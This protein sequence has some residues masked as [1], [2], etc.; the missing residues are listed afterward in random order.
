MNTETKIAQYFNELNFRQPET[1]P[2]LHAQIVP[3]PLGEMLA[4]CSATGLCL[5]EFVGQ[6]RL[7]SEIRQIAQAKRAAIFFQPHD[8]LK[9]VAEQVQSYFSGSLKQFSVPIDF[10]GTDFQQRVWRILQTIPY[11][12]TISYAEQAA[13]LG[14]P[15][16]VR[17]VAAANG[18]NKISIIVP[19]HRVIGSNGTLTGYA[20]GLSR[21]QFLLDLESRSGY[22]KYNF[23]K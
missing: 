21:K 6:A 16:A 3:T 11:G 20:G 22:L 9:E 18:R 23:P 19:C 8:L 5:L 10:V 7:D 14:N 17:A 4:I 1:M 12:E 15:K 2:P 13:K